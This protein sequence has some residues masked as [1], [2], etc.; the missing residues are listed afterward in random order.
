MKVM[1]DEAEDAFSG[2]TVPLEAEGSDKVAKAV[3]A[4]SRKQ[5]AT[6]KATVEKQMEKLFGESNSDKKVTQVKEEV[7]PKAS[8]QAKMHDV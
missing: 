2:Q 4:N 6:S 7:K 1:G 3:V 5:Y 8:T